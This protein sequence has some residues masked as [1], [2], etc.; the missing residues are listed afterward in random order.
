MCWYRIVRQ[1]RREVIADRVKIPRPPDPEQ[2]NQRA[3]VIVDGDEHVVRPGAP[4]IGTAERNASSPR[5]DAEQ[6]H[7]ERRP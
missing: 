1:G 4:G 6:P 7:M 2:I 3:R 5:P